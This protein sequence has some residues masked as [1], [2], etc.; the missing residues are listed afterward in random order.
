MIGKLAGIGLLMLAAFPAAATDRVNL[1]F[2]D[3]CSVE[4]E[5][6][7]VK[8]LTGEMGT[9]DFYV[10]NFPAQTIHKYQLARGWS[11]PPCSNRPG[12]PNC[13]QDRATA[14]LTA[15]P[16]WERAT[17]ETHVYAKDVEQP[18]LEAYQHLVQFYYTEPVGFSKVYE[19][20]IIDPANTASAA[21][22]KFYR[23]GNFFPQN[24]GVLGNPINPVIDYPDPA[25]T[26]FDI[27]NPGTKRGVLLDTVRNTMMQR[28]N[29]AMDNVAKILSALG[30]IDS[31]KLPNIGVI[32]HF[33]DGGQVTLQ[34]NN[35]S[36]VP[37][38]EI[39]EDSLRD[40]HGNYVPVKKAQLEAGPWDFD[41]SGSGR[42]KDAADM[43][44]QLEFLG[45]GVQQIV[46]AP[47]WRCGTVNM[48][49]TVSV[50][51]LPR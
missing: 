14:P 7:M 19:F 37:V 3:G 40:S 20:Q 21:Y 34:L 42:A 16:T 12:D 44:N 48:Q 10:G 30:V 5:R 38:Y 9:F 28:V 1:Y 35:S 32:V 47:Q 41:Y 24:T 27:A 15:Q 31:S 23:N 51:C 8:G 25:T 36:T 33:A 45:A 4:Q 49:G 17:M 22:Q 46:A 39:V 2:C 6:E 29:I 18:Y 11:K 13:N 26:V 50:T 43:R